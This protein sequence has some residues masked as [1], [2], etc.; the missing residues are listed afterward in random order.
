MPEYTMH[1]DLHDVLERF[2]ITNTVY[3]I[4]AVASL[5]KC[6]VNLEVFMHDAMKYR[7]K[8]NE[9]FEN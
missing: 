8:Y 2:K 4:N 3:K 1:L 9:A 5:I 7:R 6:L